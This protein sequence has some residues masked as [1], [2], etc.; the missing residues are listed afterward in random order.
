MVRRGGGGEGVHPV[1]WAAPTYCG[2]EIYMNEAE[3]STVKLSHDLDINFNLAEILWI[4]VFHFSIQSRR[5]CSLIHDQVWT[6]GNGLNEWICCLKTSTILFL[7]CNQSNLRLEEKEEKEDRCGGRGLVLVCAGV[8]RYWVTT[9]TTYN[10]R[11]TRNRLPT[12]CRLGPGRDWDT[13]YCSHV[14]KAKK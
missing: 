2:L 9:H 6:A 8:R 1:P 10:T 14:V 12:H 5:Q 11:T 4:Q 7:K 13:P 3:T